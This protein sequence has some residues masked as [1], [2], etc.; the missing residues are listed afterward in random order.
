[1]NKRR[2]QFTYTF[3]ERLAE[4]NELLREQAKALK[5]GADL[6]QLLKRIRLNESSAH[7]SQWLTSQGLRP[8]N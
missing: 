1:M 3:A 6:D 8:P 2:F 7:L 5:P 4:E